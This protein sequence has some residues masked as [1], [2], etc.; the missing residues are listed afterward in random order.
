VRKTHICTHYCPK[1]RSLPA[2]TQLAAPPGLKRAVPIP[3]KNRKADCKRKPSQ[4]NQ[5]HKRI[6][7]YEVVAN[8]V[9]IVCMQQ[10]QPKTGKAKQSR[11]E[12]I[13]RYRDLWHAAGRAKPFRPVAPE[14]QRPSLPSRRA[15][16]KEH[17]NADDDGTLLLTTTIVSQCLSYHEIAY[18]LTAVARSSFLVLL[19]HLFLPRR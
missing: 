12:N 16:D 6:I 9:E 2:R 18:Q 11:G 19:F 4:N 8:H 1:G 7:V 5:E 13:E 17:L 15:R 10:Q 3:S 14:R